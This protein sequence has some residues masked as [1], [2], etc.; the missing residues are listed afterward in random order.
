LKGYEFYAGIAKY[1]D[2][3]GTDGA[4]ADYVNLMPWGTPDQAIEKLRT[5]HTELGVAAFNPSFSFAGMP[6]DLAE[7]SIRL[8][9]TEVLPEVKRWDAPSIPSGASSA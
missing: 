8:F 2:K 9:A 6:A 5:L 3:R 1:I 4:V 7:K